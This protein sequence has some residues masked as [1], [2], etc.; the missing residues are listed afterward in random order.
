MQCPKCG[1]KIPEMNDRCL[2]CG[3]GTKGQSAS[4]ARADSSG[5]MACSGKMDKDSAGVQV[6]KEEIDYKKLE[7]LPLSVRA[8]VEAMLKKGE[9]RR[10]EIKNPFESFPEPMERTGRKRRRMG[11]L[12]ALRIL[13]KK[14]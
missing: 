6:T 14:D 10:E 8:K 4:G 5:F 1:H 9:G 3:A 12:A 7:G 11:P 13:L 2:Y